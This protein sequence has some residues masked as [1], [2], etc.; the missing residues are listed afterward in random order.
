MENPT[1]FI[2]NWMKQH[3]EADRE[4]FAGMA[5]SLKSIDAKLEPIAETYETASRMG[6]WVT[7][8]AVF[9]SIALGII[10]SFKS[11]FSVK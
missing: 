5:A 11:L 6:K 8:L 10:L 3:E 1:E 9:I 7:A 4:R 2:V